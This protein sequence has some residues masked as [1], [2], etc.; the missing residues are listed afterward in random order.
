MQLTNGPVPVILDTDIGS[1]IDDALALAYLLRQPRCDLLGVTTV[2]GDVA[3]RA[4]L[5]EVLCRAAGRDEIAIHC[6]AR[7]TLSGP[8]QPDVP[9][10]EAVRGIPHRIDWPED[11]AV[12]FMRKAIA[13]RPGEIT[14]V[15]IGP[16][17]NVARLFGRFPGTRR[18]LRAWVSMAGVFLGS[19]AH[20]D[21]N[22]VC[23]PLAT[24][25]AFRPGAL[26]HRHV[27][28]DVTLQCRLLPAEARQRLRGPLLE[29]V[30][31]MAEIWFAG[32]R[33]RDAIVFHDPL[34]AVLPFR[35]EVCPLVRGRVN[36]DP[37]TGKTSFQQDPAGP[38]EVAVEVNPQV[39][40][41][42]YFAIA[43]A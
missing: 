37:L 10:Y 42:E 2:T 15:T 13:S 31:S 35:P 11:T 20:A 17:T 28:L 32:R 43:G 3:Q 36:V 23:D 19:V 8:G 25:I 21:W 39:F 26:P 40:F 5:V 18:L 27:G 7:E 22:S 1:D 29:T 41:Q 16:L 14:L 33:E 24:V 12:E 6:G 30:L 9:Q 4:A 38:D 34:A